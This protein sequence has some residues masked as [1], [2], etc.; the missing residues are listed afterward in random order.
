MFLIYCNDLGQGRFIGDL[1]AFADDKALTYIG[2]SKYDLFD[3]YFFIWYNALI[4]IN[5]MLTVWL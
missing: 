4:I 1:N 5:L 3:T 2:P